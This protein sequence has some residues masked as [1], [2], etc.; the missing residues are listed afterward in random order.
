[1]KSLASFLFK[2]PH[3][4]CK[5]VQT[6]SDAKWVARSGRGKVGGSLTSLMSVWHDIMH[7]IS[8]SPLCCFL[9]SR[10]KTREKSFCF[11][12]WIFLL[13]FHF[14]FLTLTRGPKKCTL[15]LA[16]KSYLNGFCRPWNRFITARQPLKIVEKWFVWIT[17]TLYTI[18]IKIKHFCHK[19]NLK[20]KECNN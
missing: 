10:K 7:C 16:W 1:M 20:K 12:G 18:F 5:A 19:N 13:P 11:W 4:T 2:Y 14:D 15:H 3:P 9:L 17:C 8:S 6:Q